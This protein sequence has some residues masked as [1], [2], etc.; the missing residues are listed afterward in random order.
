VLERRSQLKLMSTVIRHQRVREEKEY[1]RYDLLC[2]QSIDASEFYLIR[3]SCIMHTQW[4][5][6]RVKAD[7]L[8][9]IGSCAETAVAVFSAV[10]HALEPLH[11]IH[12]PEVVDDLTARRTLQ[13]DA[14]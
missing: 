8:Q 14:G 9:S 5:E 12:L 10:A 4:G 6:E 13:L 7:S 1:Y 3:A 11:P 2:D